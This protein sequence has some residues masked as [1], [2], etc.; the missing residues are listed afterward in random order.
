MSTAIIQQH[1]NRIAG[2]LSYFAPAVEEPEP[3]EEPILDTSNYRKFRLRSLKQHPHCTYC[4][5]FIKEPQ[6]NLD[7]VLPVSRGG[8]DVQ[9]N[10][11][12]VCKKCNSEK[13][14]YTPAEWLEILRDQLAQCQR[15]VD[16]IEGLIAAG[17]LNHVKPTRERFT[18]PEVAIPKPVREYDPDWNRHLRYDITHGKPRYDVF[19]LT[20]GKRLVANLVL[21]VL[22]H[23][24][25]ATGDNS[26]FAVVKRM[27]IFNDEL[28]LVS[29]S[30]SWEDWHNSEPT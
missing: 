19:S 13:D 11:R 7:H 30:D 28:G 25:E 17:E 27:S 10:L 14:N 12:L 16:T 15:R 20:T 23:Y 5:K 24:L 4:G 21:H 18:E 1:Q 29:P 26:E 8:R 6:S 3:I 2:Y 22:V 9:S